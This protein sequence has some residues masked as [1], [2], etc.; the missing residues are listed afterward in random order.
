LREARG[1]SLPL[2]ALFES[3]TPRALADRLD[4]VRGDRPYNALLVLRASGAG[5]PL[6]CVHT[7]AG[8]GVEYRP[9][10]AHLD[11]D[12]PVY[13]LQAQGIEDAALFH[14]S[15]E[16]MAACY[17]ESIREIQPQGPYRFLG[18]SFG[19]AVAHEMARQLE[20]QGESVAL[21]VIMDTTFESMAG[22]EAEDAAGALIATDESECQD[23]QEFARQGRADVHPLEVPL[24]QRIIA[25]QQHVE[26]LAS[27]SFLYRVRAPILYF[28]AAGNEL[29]LHEQL[30]RVTAGAIEVIDID[31]AHGKMLDPESAVIIAEHLNRALSRL[32]LAG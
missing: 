10:L 8:T 25:F 9:L 11:V 27:A 14:A 29:S 1:V 18:W 15:V 2:R 4:E 20:A 30:A 23:L 5:V 32:P 3:P 26:R 22:S 6:F 17:I 12:T 24:M 19:G 21:L 31:E 16:E 13:S 7:G 28:R